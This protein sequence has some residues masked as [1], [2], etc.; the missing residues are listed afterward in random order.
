MGTAT[1][2]KL[3]R[4][5]KAINNLLSDIKS[6][7]LPVDAVILFGSVLNEKFNEYSDLDICIIH[8]SDLTI[9]QLRELELY[10]KELLADEVD[11]NFIY[12]N[13]EKLQ[14]GHQVFD[15][16]RKEGKVIYGIL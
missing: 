5:K 12:C 3:V 15:S 13:R 6:K 16:I 4:M 14:Q 10:F 9:R 8:E 7:V 11:A 1:D 2:L